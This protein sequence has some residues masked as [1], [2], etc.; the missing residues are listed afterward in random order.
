MAKYSVFF[1]TKLSKYVGTFEGYVAAD[2][3]YRLQ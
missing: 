2:G 3:S 1:I